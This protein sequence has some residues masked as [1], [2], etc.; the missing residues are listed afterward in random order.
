MRAEATA[1]P[2]TIAAL[3][4]AA[5]ADVPARPGFAITT[6]G[7]RQAAPS[8]AGADSTEARLFRAALLPLTGALQAAAPDPPP[9]PA[10]DLQSL[11]DTVVQRLDPSVTVPARLGSIITLGPGLTW[12]PV[13]PIRPIMAAP[14]FPQP[15][16]APLRDLSPQYILPGVDQIPAETV[17]LL[18]TNHAFLEAY[19]TGLN[20]EM[21]RQLLWAGY[22][23][24]CMGSYFRQ[25]W[26]VSG[27]VRQPGDPGDAA[28]LAEALKDIPPINTWPL[29]GPLGM[30]ENRAAVAGRQR[31]AAHPR[32]ATAPLPEHGHLRGQGQTGGQ[33]PRHRHQRRAVPDLQRD[34][35]H[36][37]HVPRVQPQR[38]RREGRHRCRT[39]GVLLRL[40]AAPDRAQVRPRAIR[41][42]PGDA[43]GRPGLD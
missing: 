33:H 6:P 17:G 26:D 9:G 27:Y 35:A 15:M 19:L 36:R 42:R 18:E 23:T 25:F 16:Y 31:R 21:A 22:P 43:V 37:H 3:T 1:G 39:R 5:V 34:A 40:R 7:T 12:H 38:R 10:L 32:R 14:T 4:P 30:H 24:D 28:A 8:A 11:R 2:V 29:S 13:D 20:H 41:R